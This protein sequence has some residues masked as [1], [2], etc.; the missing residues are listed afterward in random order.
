MKNA[1]KIL[2]LLTLMLFAACKKD[3]DTKSSESG[4]VGTWKLTALTCGDCTSTTEVGGTSATSTF[5]TT[6][7]DFTNEVTFKADGTYTASGSYTAVQ[8]I[9]VAGSTFTLE[10]PVGD[11]LGEGTYEIDGDVMT[12]KASTGETGTATILSMDS[13][14]LELKFSVNEVISSNGATVTTTGTYY[15]TL[16]K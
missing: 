2:S 9:T 6:G 7:K 8:E 4:I 12:T 10:T 16:E 15:Y 14:K 11:F 5:T 3:E 13:E 1:F